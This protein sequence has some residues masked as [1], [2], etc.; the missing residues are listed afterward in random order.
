VY[1]VKFIKFVSEREKKM[2][3]CEWCD[4]EFIGG[5]NDAE[6]YVDYNGYEYCSLDCYENALE[7]NGSEE[8]K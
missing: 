8:G 6:L 3:I 4:N 5:E 1:C 7:A 2:L